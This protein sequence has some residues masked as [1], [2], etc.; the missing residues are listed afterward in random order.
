MRVKLL[1][2]ALVAAVLVITGLRPQALPFNPGVRYSD[3]VTSHWPAAVFLRESVLER[4]AFPLWRETTMAGGPFAANP[5]NKTAYPFQWLALVLPPALHLNMLIVLHLL[6]AGAGMWRWTRVLGM[7][8]EA[9]AVSALAFA[10]APRLLAHTGAGHLD[11]V[12]AASWMPWLMAAVYQL[13]HSG[14]NEPR[15]RHFR[16]ALWVALFAALVFLADT[17]LSLFAFVTA[18]AYGLYEIR[19]RRAWR[20][21]VWLLPALLVFLLLTASVTAPLLGWSPYLSR[22][23]LTPEEAGIFSLEPAQL[24]GIVLPQQGG[25]VETL[26]YA[27]LPALLLAGIAVLTMPRRLAF[28]LVVLVVATW[29]ALGVNSLLWPLLTRVFP[30]LLWFRVPSRAWFMIAL[31]VPLLAGYGLQWLLERGSRSPRR[32]PLVTLGGVAA[33]AACGVF[34]VAA[35]PIPDNAGWGVLVGGGGTALLLFVVFTRRLNVRRAAML[36]LPLVFADALLF[37][38]SWL[39]WRGEDDWLTPY[40]PLAN[41]LTEDS[42]ARI[43]SPT[44]SLPQQAAEA[45]HLRLFGGVD[46][47]QINGVTDAVAQ[48]GGVEADGYSVV[49]PPL[50]D[51][52]GDDPATANRAAV[53]DTRLLA[54][55]DVSHVVSAYPMESARLELAQTV[56][57][58]YVYRN[59]DY[60]QQGAGDSAPSGTPSWPPGWPGLPDAET[61][62]RLNT[63]TVIAAAVSAA[64]LIACLVL[65]SFFR[66]RR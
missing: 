65:L 52:D 41:A 3:A 9:S 33:F 34:T 22:A 49:V 61:V 53:L 16:Q 11:L 51:I 63:I 43:Y 42:A 14:E 29:Y 8:P 24:I 62:E 44:Y 28:W 17:R 23:G 12:Y 31:V 66:V 46:P 50:N 36:V 15:S 60:T 56:E 37:S 30:P 6:I 48:A 1:A 4:H 25:N 35:L 40:A 32:W 38:G 2:A 18:A 57:D 21:A 13:A 20:Q 39:E 59:L 54:E 64:S 47:F 45:Y 58:V 27:G 19:Q 55:W 7:P 26:T 5:L 10:L